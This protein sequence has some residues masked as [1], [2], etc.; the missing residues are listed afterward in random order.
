MAVCCCSDSRSSLNSR[1]FSMAMTAWCGEILHQLDLLVGEGTNLL[2]IDGDDSN[3]FVVL[4]HRHCDTSPNTTELDGLDNRRMTIGISPSCCEIGEVGCLLRSKRL[5]KGALRMR[6]ER[7]TPECR[8]RQRHIV[9]RDDTECAS[10]MK[11]EVAEF[12][13]AEPHGVR[14]DGLEHRRQL[15]WRA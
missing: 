1:V 2:P 11:K 6:L 7:F 14:Q 10:F 3:Q 5:A 15:A 9:A 13:L 12:S 4:E 8:N